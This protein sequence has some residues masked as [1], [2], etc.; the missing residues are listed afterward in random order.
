VADACDHYLVEP[1]L[2]AGCHPGARGDAAARIAELRAAGITAYVDL[3]GPGELPPYAHVARPAT[4]HRRPVAD[5]GVPTD[6]DLTATL[7][8]LDRLL[9]DGATVYLHCY[10][11]VGRT[12]T[13][14]ACRLV[15]RGATPDEALAR[16]AG[17]RSGCSTAHRASPETP[18]QRALVERWA[19]VER[20]RD[21]P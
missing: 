21:V 10:A 14:V 6:E 2:L 1:R 7:D 9:A 4:H 5:F 15:R 17:L 16:I 3:T 20:H 18:A 12:G 11:G 8:L 19:Q 13:V